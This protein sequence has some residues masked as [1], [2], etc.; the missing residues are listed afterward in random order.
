MTDWL[1][2]GTQLGFALLKMALVWLVVGFLL[3]VVLKPSDMSIS[4]HSFAFG[5]HL[6]MIL[7]IV[8]LGLI[9]LTPTWFL[10][11]AGVECGVKGFVK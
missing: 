7:A 8:G 1:G 3:R 6:R 11:W 9:V 5:E 2:L 4:D 10:F